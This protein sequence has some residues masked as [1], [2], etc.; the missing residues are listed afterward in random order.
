VSGV[1]VTVR[2]GPAVAF[3]WAQTAA[4]SSD[5][6]VAREM[7]VQPRLVPAIRKAAPGPAYLE[8]HAIGSGGAFGT[9]SVGATASATTS[10]AAG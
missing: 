1:Q 3:A 6:D 9:P 4:V 2:S 10:I 5:S 7:R 8:G